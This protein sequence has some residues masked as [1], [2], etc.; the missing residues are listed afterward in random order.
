MPIA[1]FGR[2]ADRR[3]AVAAPLSRHVVEG[4]LRPLPGGVRDE[5]RRHVH[6]DLTRALRSVREHELLDRAAEWEALR[7]DPDR[8]RLETRQVE[9]LLHEPVEALA[10]LVQSL[11]KLA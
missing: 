8:P 2:D 4:G 3:C 6:L 10:L 11:A 5:V 1:L 9:Q 7:L